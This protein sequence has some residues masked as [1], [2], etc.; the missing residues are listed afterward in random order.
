MICCTA[1]IHRIRASDWPSQNFHAAAQCRMPP[2]KKCPVYDY[3]PGGHGAKWQGN[4]Y[5]GK[6]KYIV[7]G[8]GG[9]TKITSPPKMGDGQGVHGGVKVKE[10]GKT[11]IYYH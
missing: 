2:K 4:D 5:S 11:K 8:K 7:D 1:F 9:K 6:Q 3:T 10:N